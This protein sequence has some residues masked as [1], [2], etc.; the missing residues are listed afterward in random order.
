MERSLSTERLYSLADYQNIKFSN[1]L[2][3]IP[4][5]LASNQ[6]LLGLLFLQQMISCDIAYSEYKQMRETIAKE[7]IADVLGYLKERREQ[8]LQEIATEIVAETQRKS[9]TVSGWMVNPE[10]HDV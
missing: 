5:E 3:G 1:V 8:T 2:T 9:A 6:K 7:K 10:S 4:E